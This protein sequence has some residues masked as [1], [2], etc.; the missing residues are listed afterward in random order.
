MLFVCFVMLTITFSNYS[1]TN[2]GTLLKLENIKSKKINSNKKSVLGVWSLMI[3]V[4]PQP[5]TENRITFSGKETCG[6]FVDK[7]NHRGNWKLEGNKLTWEYTS[8]PNLKNTFVG[9]L[10]NDWSEMK[11][12]N[13]GSWQDNEF[14]GTW[15]GKVKKKKKHE[16]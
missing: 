3:T 1:Q 9:I 4:A 14:K 5:P 13:F 15:T 12:T 11:G 8:V 7:N 16:N 2:T 10:N 6:T